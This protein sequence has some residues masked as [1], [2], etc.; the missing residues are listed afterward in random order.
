MK[1]FSADSALV[2]PSII[3]KNDLKGYY[4]YVTEKQEEEKLVARKIYVTPGMSEGSRTMIN[5]GLAPGQ[6][7]II[8]GYNLVKNGMEVEVE[9]DKMEG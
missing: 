4:L 3:I 6:Q 2:V 9:K 5:Q 1:D 7:V 8:N